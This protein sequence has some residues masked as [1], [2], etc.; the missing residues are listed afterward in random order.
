MRTV[1]RVSVL[2]LCV[3]VVIGFVGGAVAYA[4]LSDAETATVS[5]AAGTWTTTP[6]E[7]VCPPGETVTYQ[8]QGKNLFQLK[9]N[10]GPDII[11]FSAYE[12]GNG[13]K[14]LAASFTS[15]VPINKTVTRHGNSGAFEST[16]RYSGTKSGRIT[17]DEFP[18]KQIVSVTF[19]C[20]SNENT[21]DS[22]SASSVGVANSTA[23]PES[24]TVA[25]TPM[26]TETTVE[27]SSTTT[28]VTP[29]PAAT[30]NETA[31]MDLN[32]RS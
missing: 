9:A 10:D 1:F 17:N 2:A 13:N 22:F 4:E 7:P 29:S 11:E 24:T 6:G 25:P 3:L 32:H 27:T 31:A 8:A 26:L 12:I 21:N 5:V 14:I 30:T 19:T 28:E 23:T 20:G 16:T 15:E 18:D